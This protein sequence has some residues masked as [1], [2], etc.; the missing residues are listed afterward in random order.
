MK[1]FLQAVLLILAS[2]CATQ[3]TKHGIP[4]FGVVSSK[5]RIFR[6]G[7]PT[8]EGALW[9]LEAGVTNEVKL[10][11]SQGRCC[12]NVQR[13]PITTANQIWGTALNNIV[14]RA[15]AAIRPGTFVH[16]SHGK[17]R[18][19]TVIGYY[20]LTHDGWSTKAARKEMAFYGW[21][22]SLPGLKW[23]SA[24]VAWQDDCGP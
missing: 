10:N 7:Q 24:T 6:G 4:N 20:R 15:A 2:G 21:G 22:D 14:P 23:Y 8:T 9:L 17:N 16:C 13:F 12:L 18:T 11:E 3:P 1:Y 19:G 5:D